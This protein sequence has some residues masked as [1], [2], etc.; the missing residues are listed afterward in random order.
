MLS[1]FL[2]PWEIKSFL[3]HWNQSDWPDFNTFTTAEESH[4]TRESLTHHPPSS[5]ASVHCIAWRDAACMSAPAKAAPSLRR[6]D[7]EPGGVACCWSLPCSVKKYFFIF[8][9]ILLQSTYRRKLLFQFFYL[10]SKIFTQHVLKKNV[11]FFSLPN[12]P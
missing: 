11:F 6:D 12:P 5:F 7:Y 10:S 3:R 9:S 2:R 1:S 8:Y 4:R